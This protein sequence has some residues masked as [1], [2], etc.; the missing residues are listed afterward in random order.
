M[1]ATIFS[2]CTF[3]FF[4][5]GLLLDRRSRAYHQIVQLTSGAGLR[6][7]KPDATRREIRVPRIYRTH[8]YRGILQLGGPMN[9]QRVLTTPLC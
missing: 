1:F 2:T 4:C 8:V 9:D 7:F 5:Q 3:S 6:H